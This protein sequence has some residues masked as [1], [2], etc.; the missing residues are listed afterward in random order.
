MKPYRCKNPECRRILGHASVDTFET[1]GI[2]LDRRTVFACQECG[3]R[4]VWGPAKLEGA[5][6]KNDLT[7]SLD[8]SRTSVLQS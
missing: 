4:H 3:R 8:S 5:P 7:I 1:G 6:L 2:L